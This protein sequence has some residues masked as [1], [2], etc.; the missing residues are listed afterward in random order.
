M[1]CDGCNYKHKMECNHPIMTEDTWKSVSN[2]VCF[3]MY[4]KHCVER[5]FQ[6]GDKHLITTHQI[7]TLN[8]NSM[9]NIVKYQM[10]KKKNLSKLVKL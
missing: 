6:E 10:R 9:I 2:H 7:K 5:P 3:L 8:L 1:C 4:L